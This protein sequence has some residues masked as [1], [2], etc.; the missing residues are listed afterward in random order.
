MNQVQ[1]SGTVANHLVLKQTSN[2]HYFTT[3]TIKCL[4]FNKK[5]D[6]IDVIAWHIVAMELVENVTPGIEITL[7][8]KISPRRYLKDGIVHKTQDVTLD[9]YVITKSNNTDYFREM[10]VDQYQDENQASE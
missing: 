4:R 10:E 3:F 2:A 9:N 6:Y 1:I 5:I 8:G 7:T